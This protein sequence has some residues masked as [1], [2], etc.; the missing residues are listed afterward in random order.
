MGCYRILHF[1]DEIFVGSFPSSCGGIFI[2]FPLR[3]VWNAL[4]ETCRP[5]VWNLPMPTWSV[6][7]CSTVVLLLLQFSLILFNNEKIIDKFY[8]LWAFA[9][10]H[11]VI[12][13][14]YIWSLCFALPFP[15][16]KHE[17]LVSACFSTTSWCSEYAHSWKL[18]C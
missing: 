3:F 16:S 2:S 5:N 1:F 4:W 8:A 18:L 6:H 9:N 10:Q 11:F 12:F 7:D 14:I 13:L 15:L 17:I